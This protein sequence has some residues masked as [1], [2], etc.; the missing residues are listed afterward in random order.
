MVRRMRIEKRDLSLLAAITRY[1]ILST[2]QIWAE[3]F[4]NVAKTTMLRRLRILEEEEL[5]RRVQGLP[6]GENAWIMTKHGYGA[7]ENHGTPPKFNNQNTIRHEV[8]LSGLRMRLERF[9]LGETFI[10]EWEL[11]RRLA[12]NDIKAANEKQVPD[13]IMIVESQGRPAG[14]ALELELTAKGFARYKKVVEEYERKR[15]LNFV[16]YFISDD[17]IARMLL[18]LWKK[19]DRSENGPEL[20]VTH[21][22]HLE[23]DGSRAVLRRSDHADCRIE[24]LFTLKLPD[25]AASHPVSTHIVHTGEQEKWKIPA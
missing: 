25:N 2:E 11:K 17:R 4:S 5:I 13:G 8:A 6:G 12:E 16:W 9:G 24:E 18:P 19:R 15:N 22:S 21:L 3:F 7:T 14:V 10:P 20:L 23:R 1:G